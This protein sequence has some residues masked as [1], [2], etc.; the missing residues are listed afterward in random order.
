MTDYREALDDPGRHRLVDYQAA[1]GPERSGVDVLRSRQTGTRLARGDWRLDAS[2][3]GQQAWRAEEIG[4]LVLGWHN[5]ESWDAI[6]ERIGR[7][8]YACKQKWYDVRKWISGPPRKR[9]GGRKA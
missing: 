3:D 7:D 9:G 2:V 8:P 6:G 4:A 5:G 1:C